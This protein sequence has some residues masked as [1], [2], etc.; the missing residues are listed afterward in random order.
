M[1]RGGTMGKYSL[2]RMPSPSDGT[3]E[4]GEMLEPLIPGAKPDGRPQ[5]IER[6]EILNAMP[7]KDRRERRVL[8][9]RAQAAKRA[10][11]GSGQPGVLRPGNAA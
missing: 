8:A 7:W 9:G 3:A 4:E 1:E 5:A 11:G 10:A 2:E 6:R